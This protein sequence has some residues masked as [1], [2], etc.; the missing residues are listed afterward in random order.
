VF[1]KFFISWDLG[2]EASLQSTGQGVL[3]N[4]KRLGDGPKPG[5]LLQKKKMRKPRFRERE[6]MKVS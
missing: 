3:I 2:R 6:G 5:E 1:L 4:L